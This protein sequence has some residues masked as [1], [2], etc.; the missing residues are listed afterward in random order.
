[1]N[2][3]KK[4]SVDETNKIIGGEFITGNGILVCLTILAVFVAIYKITYSQKGKAKIG[5]DFSFEWS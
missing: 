2:M 3:L 5:N 4:M 1:M